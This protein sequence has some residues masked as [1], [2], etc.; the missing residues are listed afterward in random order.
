MNVTRV[1]V[2]L[3]GFDESHAMPKVLVQSLGSA[4]MS[5]RDPEWPERPSEIALPDEMRT[6]ALPEALLLS[7]ACSDHPRITENCVE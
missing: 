3:P 5:G 4:S 1:C 2:R 7:N 6:G